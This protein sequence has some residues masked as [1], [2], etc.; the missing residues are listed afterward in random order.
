M[1]NSNRLAAAAVALTVLV[2][3]G[4]PAR[5]DDDKRP[6]QDYGAP[7]EE[8]TA[9]DVVA[10]PIRV[11]LFPLWLVTEFLVRRPIGFLVQ[12]VE[13]G[14]W[15]QKAEDVFTV[16][17]RHST[18]GQ[19]SILP[20][21]LVDVGMKTRVGFNAHWKYLIHD[22]NSARLHFATWGA[23][24]TSMRG[25]DTYELSS[26]SALFLDGSLVRASDNAF[27]GIGPFSRQDAR[28]RYASTE[29]QVAIG[30]ELDPWRS[31]A[32]RT[33]AGVRTSAP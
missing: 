30:H 28:T 16:G 26:E 5:A 7:A 18:G 32:V 12:G 20:S 33:R 25:R 22:H 6:P 10:W 21:A 27:S 4:R 1:K 13:T 17:H 31:S 11:V 15:I 2:S 3:T 23:D 9:G 24:F 8:T 14:R 29:G 19:F